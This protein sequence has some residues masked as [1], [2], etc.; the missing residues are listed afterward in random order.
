MTALLVASL[1]AACGGSETK[2]SG[3]KNNTPT[4]EGQKTPGAN[5]KDWLGGNGGDGESSEEGASGEEQ[6]FGESDEEVEMFASQHSPVDL[7]WYE[8][9]LVGRVVETGE[10]TER[11]AS[12]GMLSAYRERFLVVFGVQE[13]YC[14]LGVAQYQNYVIDT[15]ARC[16]EGSVLVIG[17]C[18][19]HDDYI[20]D[21]RAL[22][23]EVNNELY[24]YTQKE[25]DRWDPVPEGTEFQLLIG[26]AEDGTTTLYPL[27]EGLADS[28]DEVCP[29]H[30]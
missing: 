24:E 20:L 13:G 9:R 23:S 12:T 28:W 29:F 6:G 7:A 18:S 17:E 8:G 1:V 21:F 19:V 3:K 26:Q 14:V 11:P 16:Y 22:A 27:M 15:S 4:T 10:V 5:A 25:E 2:Q 30:D